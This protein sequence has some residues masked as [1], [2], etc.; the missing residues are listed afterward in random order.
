MEMAVII[1]VVLVI[2]LLNEPQKGTITWPRSHR[3]KWHFASQVCLTPQANLFSSHQVSFLPLTAIT[4]F[5][6]NPQK[7]KGIGEPPYQ[8]GDFFLPHLTLQHRGGGR[9][10]TWTVDS[11]SQPLARIPLKRNC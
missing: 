8:N 7:A 6:D 9:M 11:S 2:I 10:H 3:Y 1:I 4:L 5:P